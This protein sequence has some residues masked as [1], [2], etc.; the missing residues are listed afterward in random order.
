MPSNG[1]SKIIIIII[2]AVVLISIVILVWQYWQTG[3]TTISS[4]VISPSRQEEG[5]EGEFSEIPSIPEEAAGPKTE[6]ANGRPPLEVLKNMEYQLFECPT[7]S[8][9][10]SDRY[11]YLFD[12]AV[13]KVKLKNGEYDFYEKISEYP[14]SYSA[15]FEVTFHEGPTF[16]DLNNDNIDDALVTLRVYGGGTGSIPYLAAVIIDGDEYR[17]IDTIEI[18]GDGVYIDSINKG[19]ITIH[20]EL[21]Y[22]SDSYL[23]KISFSEEKG[24]EM[25]ESKRVPPGF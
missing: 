14:G 2:S 11:D 25:L 1:F 3:K 10:Y 9:Y 6:K 23:L 19:I 15:G 16:A 7:S 5:K 12:K 8:D 13:C 4:S 20:S 18:P 22:E 21:K 17:N 24:F